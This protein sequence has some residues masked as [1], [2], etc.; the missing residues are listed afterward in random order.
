MAGGSDVSDEG[1]AL[2]IPAQTGA[3]DVVTLRLRKPVI[4]WVLE[5]DVVSPFVWVCSLSTVGRASGYTLRGESQISTDKLG[6]YWYPSRTFRDIYQH[7][8]PCPNES[9][10]LLTRIV[11]MMA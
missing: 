10:P 11:T 1:R 5:H 6:W 2:C 3:D 7:Q 8:S 4:D 9:R